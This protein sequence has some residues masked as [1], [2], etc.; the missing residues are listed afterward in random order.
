[1]LSHLS[2]GV[3]DLKVA[4]LFYGAVLD[5]LGLVEVWSIA[6]AAGYGAPGGEDIFAIKEKALARAPGPGFHLAF[7]AST[8]AAVDRWHAA[9][10]EAGGTDEGPPGLRPHYGDPYYAAFL[11]DP[12]KYLIEAVCNV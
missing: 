7:N 1:M 12:D 5:P 3:A 2:F 9:G 11:R 6:E 4:R 10:I 8:R